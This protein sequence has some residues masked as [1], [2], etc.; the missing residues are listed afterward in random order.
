MIFIR[1]QATCSTKPFCIIS[2]FV[3]QWLSRKTMWHAVQHRRD[4]TMHWPITGCWPRCLPRANIMFQ[5]GKNI[6]IAPGMPNS[7]MYFISDCKQQYMWHDNMQQWMKHKVKPVWWM[8][9]DN[10]YIWEHS[11]RHKRTTAKTQVH[12]STYH[13]QTDCIETD[14]CLR[15]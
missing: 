3:S 12:I 11:T 10:K 6:S 4:D 8:W 15:Q 2:A 5:P 14:D 1:N 13:R 7:D 9:M